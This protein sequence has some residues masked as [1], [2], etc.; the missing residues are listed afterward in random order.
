MLEA[1]GTPIPEAGG[2]ALAHRSTE[3]V[4]ESLVEAW[5]LLTLPWLV[6]AVFVVRKRADLE[7]RIRHDREY[8]EDER[9]CDDATEHGLLLPMQVPSLRGRLYESARTLMPRQ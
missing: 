7:E 8:P 9:H 1:L 2:I 4:V 6:V 5:A 3:S